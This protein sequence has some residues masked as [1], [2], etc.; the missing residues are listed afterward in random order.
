MISKAELIRKLARRAGV[1]D[2]EAKLFFEI[3]LKRAAEILKPGSAV[4]IKQ[5]GYLQLKRGKIKNL[6]DADGTLSEPVY[7]DLMVFSN[8]EVTDNDNLFFN[9]PVNVV[10]K[11]HP[12]DLHF[13]LSIGKPV[14]PLKN[15]TASQHFHQPGGLELQRLIDSKVDK[16]F[17]EIEVIE[18]YSKG[19]DVLLIDASNFN[20]NQM[21]M[22]LSGSISQS[23]AVASEKEREKGASAFYKNG[24]NIPWDFGDDLSKQI[25]EESILDLTDAEQILFKETTEEQI[26]ETNIPLPFTK[27]A[28]PPPINEEDF[29]EV[30]AAF[31]D[32]ILPDEKIEGGLNKFSLAYKD[33]KLNPTPSMEIEE[34]EVEE[35]FSRLKFKTATHQFDV[36]GELNLIP[37]TDEEFTIDDIEAGDEQQEEPVEESLP[38]VEFKPIKIE[39]PQV[40]ELPK[41]KNW[42]F[43]FVIAGLILV[44][45]AAYFIYINLDMFLNKKNI[46]KHGKVEKIISS[47]V[48]RTYEIPVSYPYL[49]EGDSLKPVS[50]AI[51]ITTPITTQLKEELSVIY[52]TEAEKIEEKNKKPVGQ[53]EKI[54]EFIYKYGS[55]YFVQVSSWSSKNTADEQATRLQRAGKTAILEKAQLAGG[56]IRYRVL[57]GKFST[58]KEAEDFKNKQ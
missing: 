27:P 8:D 34:E 21:E 46:A 28:P 56:S 47:A 31:K 51:N 55:N 58:L 1:P 22:N 24:N 43:V 20:P 33:D 10:Q 39:M 32:V 44:S 54:K 30:K 4:F 16:L 53:A 23:A 45:A 2:Q 5:Y 7:T 40:A 50:Q 25:E 38:V 14:I 49:P 6:P 52:K 12:L 9:I 57:V 42:L 13:S 18:D 48:N 15:V 17:K 35:G 41:K 29:Q 3:F 11:H 36:P 37:E 19:E 26:E